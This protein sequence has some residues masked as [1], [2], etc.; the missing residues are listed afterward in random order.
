MEREG[1]KDNLM[2]K[3]EMESRRSSGFMRKFLI[4]NKS[5]VEIADMGKM[6]KSIVNLTAVEVLEQRGKK[7]KH[8]I[9]GKIQ[10]PAKRGKIHCNEYLGFWTNLV[11]REPHTL[12]S[13]KQP[14]GE[15][16]TIESGD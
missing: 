3:S 7:R 9:T 1:E 6:E 14:G 10:S 8:S 2:I 11:E 16:R 15:T 12:H 5:N 4:G 13:Y